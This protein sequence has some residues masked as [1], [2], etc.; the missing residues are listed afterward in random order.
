MPG[1]ILLFIHQ[2][3]HGNS[4][5]LV[6]RFYDWLYVDHVSGYKQAIQY[7]VDHHIDPGNSV[8]D[9]GCGTGQIIDYV[10]SKA[11]MVV[12]IDISLQMLKQTRKKLSGCND[13][14]LI[15]ADSRNLLLQASFDKIVSCFMLVILSREDRMRVIESMEP[16][17]NENG[18]LIFLTAQESLSPQWLTFDEWR[19]FCHKAGFSWVEKV[20]ILDCYRIIIV[21]LSYYYRIIIARKNSS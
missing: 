21:L 11:D 17:L 4:M 14:L 18:A 8:L 12:G 2:I 15:S 10:K 3:M 9:V 20:D 1:G 16:L 13:V 5:Y 7:L 19:S 6:G